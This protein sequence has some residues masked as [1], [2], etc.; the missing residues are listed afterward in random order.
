MNSDGTYAWMTALSFNLIRKNL[1]I[2]SN[3]QYI[4]VAGLTNP[5]DVIQLGSSTGT[6]AN[7]QRQ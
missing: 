2:D 7:A 6:I 3:E 4:Y 5:L 1:V